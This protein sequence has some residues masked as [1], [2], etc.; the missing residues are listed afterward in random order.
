MYSRDKEKGQWEDRIG[1]EGSQCQHLL[2][3]LVKCHLEKYEEK[4]NP[5]KR[6]PWKEYQQKE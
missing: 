5:Y 6:T 3:L 2:L 4:E 1:K